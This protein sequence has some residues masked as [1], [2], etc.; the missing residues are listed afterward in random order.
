MPGLL[1]RVRRRPAPVAFVLG[2]GGNLGA[3]QAGMLR[4]LVEHG[5][6][7]DLVVGCS[8]GALNGAAFAQEPTL[9]GVAR[10]E[11]LWRSL[12][13]R[14]VMPS[15]WMPTAVQFARRGVAVHD[16][17]GL[18]RLI[19]AT[20]T[21]G[22]FEELRV[23]F[24]CVATDLDGARETWFSSGSLVD[25]ILASSAIPSVYPPVEIDGVRYVDGAVVNDVPV[26]RAVELGARRLYVLHVGSFDRPLPVPRR[27]LD[28]A[29]Q[30]Y[31]IARRHRFNRDI[32]SLPAGIEAVV[33]PPGDPPRMRFDDFSRSRELIEAAYAASA[34]LLDSREADPDGR[35]LP[36]RRDAASFTR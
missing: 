11:Q 27:P 24:E 29:V 5:V 23:P 35:R 25:P 3:V 30:A 2:G 7:P 36:L 4:A 34:A 15:G 6:V 32:S 10:I 28:V 26:S 14:D 21:V 22:T 8:V 12:D 18:R 20:L 19:E 33:L 31:W 1:E 9:V 16:N 13:G 17:E